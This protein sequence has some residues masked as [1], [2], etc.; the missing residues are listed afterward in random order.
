MAG[1]AGVGQAGCVLLRYPGYRRNYSERGFGGIGALG[2]ERNGVPSQNQY[3]PVVS[4]ISRMY[5][6]TKYFF[7]EL[8]FLKGSEA[9]D[10]VKNI[11]FLQ[12]AE[13]LKMF[14][15]LFP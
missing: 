13:R 8:T 15:H 7:R 2:D 1:A 11:T 3:K 14:L 10:E 5:L 12:S 6:V 9:F 4:F